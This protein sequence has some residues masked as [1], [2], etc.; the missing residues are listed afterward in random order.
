MYTTQDF[1]HITFAKSLEEI[2]GMCNEL[3][4]NDDVSDVETETS[5]EHFA[6]LYALS[7][8]DE[9]GFEITEDALEAHLDFFSEEG[10]D[11]CLAT[12]QKI[13]LELNQR[14]A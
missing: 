7:A 13:A 1:S 9:S 5:R 2:V 3:P 4:S 8:A 6:A 12:A 11:F 14:G 10:A